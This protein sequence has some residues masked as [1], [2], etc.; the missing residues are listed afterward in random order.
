MAGGPVARISVRLQPGA[1]RTSLE[2]WRGDTLLAKVTAPP[3]RGRANQALLELL[4]GALGVSRGSLRV[5]RGLTSRNKVVEVVGLT[6][7][8]AKER[9]DRALGGRP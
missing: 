8:G 3:E 2:G 9:L 4:A 6:P 5:V 1:R 7:A